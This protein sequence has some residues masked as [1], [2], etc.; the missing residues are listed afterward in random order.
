MIKLLEDYLNAFREELR[1]SDRAV[2]QD[3]LSD[4]EDHLLTAMESEM[5]S[6]PNETQDEA[7][8]KVIEKY[9]EPSEVAD[10][11]RKVEQ[12]TTPAISTRSQ[13]RTGTPFFGI[14]AD[15]SA[16]ASV[17]Y[18]HFSLV[19]GIIY[20][21][22]TVTGLSLSLS[23]MVLV[24]GLPLAWLF[25]LSF[26]GLAFIEGRIVEALLGV[27]MPRR[28]V[29]IG[30]GE[31]WWKSIKGVFSTAST[32]SS[33]LYLILMLPLGVLYFSVFVS[34][35]TAS[36]SMIADPVL[37]LVFKI[38]VFDFNKPFW[39]PVWLMPLVVVG[40]VMLLLSTLH[41]AKGMGKLQG[42][43]ARKMLVSG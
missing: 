32:W 40:G 14:I 8:S 3:A 23:M 42:K 34:L 28:T 4:A 19:T 2:V 6:N 38:Q 13:K 17:L 30:K 26:R 16:W 9:G 20:F 25:F 36:L 33:M 43:L 10:Y 11:Y 5:A 12:Y 18:M 7:A 24:I 35:F 22:W 31:G 37:E 41:L 15:P 39:M 1:G 27:R 29:Y 21:T